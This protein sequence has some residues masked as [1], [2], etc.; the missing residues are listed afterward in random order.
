[1]IVIA[2]IKISFEDNRHPENVNLYRD[3]II[4]DCYG[5]KDWMA[6]LTGKRYDE[7]E[8]EDVAVN[9]RYKY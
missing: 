7:I 1:M 5:L 9:W 6:H 8:L 4:E 2:T 3:A